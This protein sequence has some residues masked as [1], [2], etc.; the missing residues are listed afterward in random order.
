MQAD[1]EDLERRENA[2]HA[3]EEHTAVGPQGLPETLPGSQKGYPR[4][5]ERPMSWHS[6]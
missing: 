1:R 6:C 3:L 4:K 5:D 2:M